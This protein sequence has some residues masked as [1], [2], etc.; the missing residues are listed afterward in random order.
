MTVKS[1]FLAEISL[2]ATRADM[3]LGGAFFGTLIKR[4]GFWVNVRPDGT[5]VELLPHTQIITDKLGRQ[6][7]VRETPMG[8]V[9]NGLRKIAQNECETLQLGAN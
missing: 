3:Y 9:L 5:T 6:K 1:I 8:V 4:A 2:G 7:E